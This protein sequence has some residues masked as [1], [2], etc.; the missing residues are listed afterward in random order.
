MP[1]R[2]SRLM[3]EAPAV[4]SVN[5]SLDAS[6]RDEFYDGD[7]GHADRQRHGAA[8]RLARELPQ[9]VALLITTMASIYTGLAAHHRLRRRLQQRAHLAFR[10]RPGIGEPAGPRLQRGEVLRILLLELALL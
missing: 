9:D 6:R 4:N 1:R 2:L 7:Q 3:R 8:A 10:A 5:V